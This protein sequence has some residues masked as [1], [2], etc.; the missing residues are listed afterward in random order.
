VFVRSEC[1]EENTIDTVRGIIDFDN[2]RATRERQIRGPGVGIVLLVVAIVQLATS[3]GMV[4]Q[5]NPLQ[6]RLSEPALWSVHERNVPTEPGSVQVYAERRQS[7]LAMA[8]ASTLGSLVGAGAGSLIGVRTTDSLGGL[9]I[10]YPGAWV[11]AAVGAD[12]T[13]ASL[14]RSLLASAVGLVAGAAMLGWG[15]DTWGWTGFGV[16]GFV[17]A[18]LAGGLKPPGDVAGNCSDACAG[19]SPQLLITSREAITR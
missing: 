11:G 10:G 2:P 8:F 4:A 7:Y 12:L 17:T 18:L 1:I 16:H 6:P 19:V 15:G 14:P 3:P 9:L 5:E 13:G